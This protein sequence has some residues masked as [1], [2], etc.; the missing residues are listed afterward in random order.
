MRSVH[1][2]T[3]DVGYDTGMAIRGVFSTRGKA[4]SW[5]A[6]ARARHEQRVRDGKAAGF[7][8][9]TYDVEEYQIDEEEP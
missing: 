5:I 4:D 1:V 9:P 6:A 7:L 3:E 2:V 8:R